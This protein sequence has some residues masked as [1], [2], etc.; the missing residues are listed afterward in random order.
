MTEVTPEP[1]VDA[2]KPANRE[3]MTRSI[4]V[5]GVGHFLGIELV[6]RLEEDERYHR[7]LAIDLYRP[8]I[9]FEKTEFCEVDLTMPAADSDLARLFSEADVDTVV[10]AAFLSRP[11]HATEWAHELEDIGTMHVLNACAEVRPAQL[12]LTS[13]TMVYGASPHNPNYLDESQPLRGHADSRFI[14][15]KVGAER[16]TMRFARENA[17]IDV[18]VLRF[19]PILGPTIDNLFTRFFSRP[20][21]PVMMGH[22]P[23]LQFV[24]ESDAAR[25]L[26][27]AIDIGARGS[28]NIVGK[29][30]LPYTTVLALMGRLPV[31]M[32]HVVA[33]SLSRLLWVTQVFDS[34]PSFLDFLRYLCVADGAR[35]KRELGFT[36]RYSI[37]RTVL[38][39]LG[40]ATDDGAPD[41]DRIYG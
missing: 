9:P 34:P 5:I 6:K 8:D 1:I 36:A 40:V 27:R 32:P 21:A 15:D 25:A 22:D 33:R 26:K 7:V 13:S 4:A 30:V 23:L 12:V 29:G 16:Q 14:N 2:E 24:H 10:H 35:A 39:F 37:Q 11:T 19:A 31:T 38:D 41:P 28:F 18:G 17:D 3:S 20:I